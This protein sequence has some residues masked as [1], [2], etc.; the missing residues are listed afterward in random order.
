LI[1]EEFDLAMTD[2]SRQT[3]KSN[4]LQDLAEQ[5]MTGIG[6]GDLAFAHLCDQRGI[7]LAGG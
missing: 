4:Q 6:N 7:T 3:G 1:G 2:V 5:G